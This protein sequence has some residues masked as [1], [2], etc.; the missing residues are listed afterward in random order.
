MILSDS[1]IGMYE[2]DVAYVYQQ[3]KHALVHTWVAL[4]NAQSLDYQACR[5]YLKF[6]CSIIGEGDEQVD[7]TV[8]EKGKNSNADALLP[9]HIK[10]EA[11][12]LCVRLIRAEALPKMDTWGGTCEAYVQ[13]EFGGA[14]IKTRA[15]EADKRW[16]S[17]FWHEDILIPVTLPCVSTQLV[18]SVWD[19]DK[20][21]DDDIIGTL[22]LHWK[23]IV[24]KKYADYTW[25]NIYGAPL[26]VYGKHTDNMNEEPRI[27]SNWR[28]R[29]LC[30]LDTAKLK[31]PKSKLNPIGD[32]KIGDEMRDKFDHYPKYELRVQVY[33]GNAFPF[34]DEDYKVVVAWGDKEVSS[35]EKEAKNGLV[36]WYECL[37]WTMVPF[38]FDHSK[39]TLPPNVI[40]EDIPDIFIYLVVDGKKICFKRLDPKKN[41]DMRAGA[42]WIH[43]KPDKA[44]GKV[45]KDWEGGFLR[46]RV[47]V[48]RYGAWS[49]QNYKDEGWNLKPALP[50]QERKI[51]RCNL[52]QCRSLPAADS[53]ARADP[54]V[55]F[56]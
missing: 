33:S 42:R 7:L 20:V 22:R 12:Q 44:I 48:G 46:M 10:Q 27:A 17:S 53:D 23:D 29:I 37:G 55:R 18:L 14:K 32:P 16:F 3:P 43:L 39:E 24:D 36:D 1:L 13:V 11:V 41:T 9:P 19:Y 28:G 4:S 25:L 5:G 40:P 26:K 6:G 52:Y 15:V 56:Y 35:E 50:P 21:G 47:G 31:K 2:M 34:K 54:Y 8:A 49:E 38:P 30:S 51:L 45:T